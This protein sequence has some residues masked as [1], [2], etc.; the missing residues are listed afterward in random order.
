MNLVVAIFVS[1]K[2]AIFNSE[3][4]SIEDV[5]LWWAEERKLI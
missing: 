3:N 1:P 4:E 2:V 5:S